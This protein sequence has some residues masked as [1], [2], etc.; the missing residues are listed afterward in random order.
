MVKIN[1]QLICYVLDTSISEFGSFTF[2]TIFVRNKNV[3]FKG[4]ALFKPVLWI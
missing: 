4:E 3:T 2:L 1:H